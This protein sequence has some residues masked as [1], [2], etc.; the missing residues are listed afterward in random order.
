MD[1]K[2]IKDNY[3]K[4]RENERKSLSNYLID[5]LKHDER[6]AVVTRGS[7]GKGRIKYG[8]SGRFGEDGYNLSNWKWVEVKNNEQKDCSCIISLNMLETDPNSGNVHALYDRIGFF[9]YTNNKNTGILTDE[10]RIITDIELPLDDVKKLKIKNI[11]ENIV[12]KEMWKME[13]PK[14]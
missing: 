13:Y 12:I 10:R 1:F 7:S 8:S 4:V 5:I 14:N 9:V 6:L 11:I 3:N 2:D